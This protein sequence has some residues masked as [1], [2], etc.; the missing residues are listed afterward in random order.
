MNTYTKFAPN[1]F[2]A[3]CEEEHEKGEEITVT[4][5]YGKEN[6]CIVHNFLGEKNG[7]FMY[8]ITR[9]DGFNSQERARKK[10]ERL[11]GYAINAE[12]RS[13]DWR[14]KSNEGNE[15]LKMAEPIKIGHHS[16]KKHRALIDRN[17]RRFANS[18]EEQ[19]KAREYERKAEYWES[20]AEK[21]DL[22]MPESLEYF[23]Y[24]LDQATKFHADMKAG[25]IERRHSMALQYAKRD[26][27][28]LS[29]KVE[30][31]KRLWG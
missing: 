19:K 21:I 3:L 5:R 14:E 6:E 7:K 16:E 15:F 2:V 13:D 27:N 30:L 28:D 18:M 22:S 4:T 29:K 1:V 17:H 9:S 26:V 8:S 10:A 25:K 12:K 31:A 20:M 24:R 23:E 11:N